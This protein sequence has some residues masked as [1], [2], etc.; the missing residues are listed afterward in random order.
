LEATKETQAL[1][2]NSFALVVSCVAASSLLIVLALDPRR[3]D[4]AGRW[5]VLYGGALAVLNAVGA[6]GL[7][8]WSDR[9]P[10]IVFLR[11][12]LWGT[13]GRMVTL[14]LGVAVGIRALGLPRVPLIV[15]LLSYFLLFFVMQITILHRR[16]PVAPGGAL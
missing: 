15:S 3:L 14:L 6:Y 13:L 9:R 2:L 7:V 10:T 11:T 5:A 1:S 16:A 8:L 12:V 4:A